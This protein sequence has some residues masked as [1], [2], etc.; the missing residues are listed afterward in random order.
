MSL[1]HGSHMSLIARRLEL[2]VYKDVTYTQL[3]VFDQPQDVF[4]SCWSVLTHSQPDVMYRV[5]MCHGFHVYFLQISFELSYVL[6]ILRR[7][8][9]FP[10]PVVLSSCTAVCLSRLLWS[11]VVVYRPGCRLICLFVSGFIVHLVNCGH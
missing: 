8:S 2:L 5:I 7:F 6:S 3:V 10:V 1:S 4:V 11:C 9:V